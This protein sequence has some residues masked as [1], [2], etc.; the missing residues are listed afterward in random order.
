M[1]KQRQSV[2]NVDGLEQLARYFLKMARS[3]RFLGRHDHRRLEFGSDRENPEL[4]IRFSA[5]WGRG[6]VLIYTDGL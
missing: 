1:P 5:V 3:G 4:T 2:A 6:S